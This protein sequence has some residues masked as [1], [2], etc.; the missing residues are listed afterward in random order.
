[1]TKRKELIVEKY[2]MLEKELVKFLNCDL[3]PDI[4]C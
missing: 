2:L 3:F 4:G 1:M